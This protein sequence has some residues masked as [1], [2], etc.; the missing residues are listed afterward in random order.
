MSFVGQANRFGDAWVRPHDLE[1]ALEPN[2][3]T[4]E[5]QIERVV[6]LGFEVRCELVRDDG[7]PFSV[8]LTREQA[9]ALE[10]ERGQIVYARPTRERVFVAAR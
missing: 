3:S 10:L 8:Q 2:G 1:L 4:R 6:Q 7:E 9:E 5:A